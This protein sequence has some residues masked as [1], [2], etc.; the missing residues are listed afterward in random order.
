MDELAAVR[1]NESSGGRAGG[2]RDET[3][4]LQVAKDLGTG[5]LDA[6]FSRLA[7]DLR[8]LRFL[9]GVVD[10]GEAAD[11]PGEG[12]LV[13]A[14]RVSLDEDGKGTAAV[15]LDEASRA[16]ARLPPR[17][18]IGGD[19]GAQGGDPVLGEERGDDAHAA[20]VL[21]AILLGEA[22]IPCEVLADDVAVQ[23][24]HVRKAPALELL[25][26]RLGERGLP[27]AREPGEPDDEPLR[28]VSPP[29]WFGSRGSPGCGAE[30]E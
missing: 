17:L 2:R 5:F 7:H 6:L 12:L 25:E 4:P 13:Q 8:P 1:Q 18:A 20:D 9:V 21:V 3:T 14:L 19:E 22:K 24:L 23:A 26:E 10:S 30:R 29:S 15:D 16:G 11:L 28:H 27:R